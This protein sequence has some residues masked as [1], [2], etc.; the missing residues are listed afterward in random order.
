M[1]VTFIIGNGFD[2]SLGMKSRYT[3]VYQGYV[4]EFSASNVV[5]KFKAEL[6]WAGMDNYKN[7][8][9]FEMGIANY[10]KKFNSEGELIECMRDFKRYMVSHLRE[11]D[12]RMIQ[13]INGNVVNYRK[14][15]CDSLENFYKGLIPNDIRTIENIIKIE[16]V[17]YNYLV[18]NYTSTFNLL[19]SMKNEYYKIQENEPINIHGTLNNDVVLGVDSYR[20]ISDID[21]SLSRKAQRTLIKPV[22]NEQYDRLRVEEAMYTIENS[23]VICAYGF[24][25]GE[26]DHTW[27]EAIINWLS[28]NQN[29]HIIIFQYDENVYHRYNFDEIMDVEE[30]RKEIFLKKWNVSV[31]SPI[32]DQI[33]IP[34]GYDIFNFSNL[35]VSENKLPQIDYYSML[36]SK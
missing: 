8:S 18:F 10:A 12:S 4:T 3:D 32:F 6:R 29:H 31:D 33:H 20:Q 36:Y 17:N 11:E 9:D 13:Q 16:S 14:E 5:N 19:V 25:F 21:Y 24:S 27:I 2:L 30:E 7:W 22:F 15:F 28:S 35:S 23:D 34:V 26:S 1:N